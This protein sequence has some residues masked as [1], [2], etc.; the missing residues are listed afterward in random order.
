[1][2]GLLDAFLIAS[3]LAIWLS[4]LPEER[5]AVRHNGRSARIK[6]RPNRLACDRSRGP[7]K[8]GPEW[9]L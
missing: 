8:S 1:M 5:Q 7:P 6:R 9:F 3:P 2:L 4:N